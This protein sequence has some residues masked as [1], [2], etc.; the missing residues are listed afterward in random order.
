M[1]L[2]E[3][4]VTQGL[5]LIGGQSENALVTPT[6][7]QNFVLRTRVAE[8]P[9][10]SIHTE[11]TTFSRR[12]KWRGQLTLPNLGDIATK[13]LV[14]ERTSGREHEFPVVTRITSGS[15]SPRTEL[16]A[17]FSVDWSSLPTQLPGEWLD[18]AIVVTTGQRLE[19]RVGV[20]RP[21]FRKRLIHRVRAARADRD[22]E[23]RYYGP[24]YTYRARNLA[25]YVA[26]ISTD[27]AN[28]ISR[29]GRFLSLRRAWYRLTNP[30]LWIVGETGFKA[31]DTGLHLFQH[32]REHHPE[33]D[34]R[35]VIDADS[36][37]RE[38]VESVGPILI[39][40]EPEH[41]SAVLLADKLIGSHHPEYL[42]PVRTN[43]FK[44][45]V[46]ATKVFQQHGIMG[47][48]W[49]ANLYGHGVAGFE[50]DCFLV[51]S[52][53]EK[54]MVQRDF[55]YVSKR[56]VVTGLSR[57]DALLAPS[58]PKRQLL[59][60]PTWRD[61][62]KDREGLLDSEFYRQW[63]GLVR[64]PDFKRVV[65]EAEWQVKLILHP[66][67]RNFTD[68]FEEENIVVVQQ[69]TETV[70]DLL[71]T[72][73]VL[74][75]DFSSV[76]FDFALLG[77]SVVYFQ[78]DRDRFLGRR[79]SHLDLDTDLPGD[80]AF[81]VEGVTRALEAASR[82][83]GAASKEALEKARV[84]FPMMDR[85]SSARVVA[86]VKGA[87]REPGRRLRS[88]VRRASQTFY[89]RFRRSRFYFPFA[90]RFYLMARL[91][92][93]KSNWV[94]F[95]S[96]LGKQYGDSP[97][98]IY[99]ELTR[100]RPDMRKT[101]FY[102]GRISDVDDATEIVPRLSL[103]Y[104][105]ALARAQY[106]VNNQSFPHY[107]R[108]R[109]QQFFVQTWHGTPLKRMARD[110][111]EIHGR[112]RGYLGRALTAARQWSLLVSPNAYTSAVMESAFDYQGKVLEVG[113]PRNDALHGV[114]A[115]SLRQRVRRALGIADDKRIVLLAP[116]FRDRNLG[117]EGLS[118]VVQFGFEQ[119][120]AQ[121]P[122]DTVLLLRRHVLD[123]GIVP[124]PDHQGRR[125]LD[126]TS[127][128]DIQ[129]LLVVADVLVTDYSSVYFDY[130]NLQR[131]IVFFAPDLDDYRDVLRGFYLDYERDLPGP[132]AQTSQRARELV[133]EALEQGSL[134]GYDLE[135][136]ADRYCPLDDGAAA[137]RV[138][139]HV[140]GPGSQA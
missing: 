109:K 27:T 116:T 131:P 34:A 7:I 78:F 16:F 38:L 137:K 89:R 126:V 39:H 111:D 10:L 69:G 73:A 102:R 86:A 53:S 80:I 132:I 105:Y 120:L 5:H 66:N 134:E 44:R 83:D 25:S 96:G 117:Q 62:I 36:P 70:Q 65:T 98:A 107:I 79:G 13:L 88:I 133:V 58:T 1:E 91:L 33:I 138:V 19:T 139:D 108:R 122:E 118:P 40:G 72:S 14:T 103:R 75:T 55:G 43:E 112:D 12:V 81:D 57:F 17:T 32:L 49:M 15:D 68:L 129:D 23:T 8:I 74:L 85:R 60:I 29:L 92:P 41:A 135:E 21:V 93:V 37:D 6:G 24:F 3:D 4:T 46:R 128:P 113:Y 130:L 9:S 97:K 84:F 121:A 64:S 22:G 47:T 82:R 110:I 101:W 26:T 104:Y 56:V 42:Y 124:I 123:K 114:S 59:V 48:K 2:A 67:F 71:R 87:R 18:F 52:P 11:R 115:T 35:F 30:P 77:R 125:I 140:F 63:V 28:Q 20:P 61:W 54:E 76:G 136:F 50:A 127:Y 45:K 95:E 94:V 100:L 106:W 119:W 99:R 90:R 51:S 31:Q